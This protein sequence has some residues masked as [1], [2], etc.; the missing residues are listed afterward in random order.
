MV[1]KLTAFQAY[2]GECGTSPISSTVHE[3]QLDYWMISDWRSNMSADQF[4][5]WAVAILLLFPIDFDARRGPNIVGEI[6]Q[7]GTSEVQWSAG[8][9]RQWTHHSQI[10]LTHTFWLNRRHA[11]NECSI[12]QIICDGYVWTNTNMWRWKWLFYFNRVS[13]NRSTHPLGQAD[14]FHPNINSG[15][16]FT[17]RHIRFTWTGKSSCVPR[18]SF[19][20]IA[21]VHIGSLSRCTVQIRRTAAANTRTAANVSGECEHNRPVDHQ[22][23]YTCINRIWIS[24][25]PGGQRNADDQIKRWCRIQ[26]TDGTVTWR[27]LTFRPSHRSSF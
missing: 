19:A 10:M 14:W 21:S 6:N 7:F 9:C 3:Y 5:V 23:N 12:W 17:N 24:R 8:K 2:S 16:D 15:R 25:E 18:E 13:T 22:L 1:Q 4:M 26:L 27:T 20:S 11:L